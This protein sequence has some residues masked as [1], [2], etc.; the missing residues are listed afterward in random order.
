MNR[1]QSQRQ[2][3]RSRAQ[4]GRP[5]NQYETRQALCRD[6]RH[7][8]NHLGATVLICDAGYCIDA[9]SALPQGGVLA[10]GM[11]KQACLVDREDV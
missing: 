11:F 7:M 8:P 4:E 10:G 2:L 6:L 9:P 5:L 3:I 1:K